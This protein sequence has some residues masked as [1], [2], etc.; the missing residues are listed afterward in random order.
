MFSIYIQEKVNKAKHYVS[1]K[2]DVLKSVQPLY[3]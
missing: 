2:V 1:I 3:I